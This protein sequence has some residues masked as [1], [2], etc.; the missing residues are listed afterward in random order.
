MEELNS[1]PRPYHFD[2]SHGYVSSLSLVPHFLPPQG[3]IRQLDDEV[4]ALFS[5][6]SNGQ[7]GSPRF[8]PSSK[9]SSSFSSSSS[10]L[11]PT[12]SSSRWSLRNL[13]PPSP[14]SGITSSVKPTRPQHYSPGRAPRLQSK[15]TVSKTSASASGDSKYALVYKGF[16]LHQDDLLYWQL[17][18]QFKG[19]KV[20]VKTLGGR[21]LPTSGQPF[22]VTENTA[23]LV[24]LSLLTALQPSSSYSLLPSPSDVHTPYA[25]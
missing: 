21:P 5:N 25:H 8:V 15:N 11:V 20:T 23:P 4:W 22:E 13:S 10:S 14:P 1:E 18:A 17:P 24:C 19:D 3:N 16:S 7:A 12:S 6:F 9:S 2:S